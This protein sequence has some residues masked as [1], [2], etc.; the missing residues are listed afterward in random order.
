[1]KSSEKKILLLYTHYSSFVKADFE[2]LSE[3][4]PVD[5]Y[6]FIPHKKLF[7]FVWQFFKQLSFL[8]LKGWKY[9]VFFIWFADYHSL[10]P[11]LFARS[12]GKKSVV[13]VGGYD[14]VSI[15]E[16]G[17]GL[18]YRKNLR[19]WF[20]NHSFRNAAVILP[21]DASLIQST[22]YFVN[23]EGQK[24]GILNYV[25][26]IKALIKTVPTGYRS[27]FWKRKNVKQ[28]GDVITVGGCSDTK[29]FRRKG[30]DFFLELALSMPQYYFTLAGL[31]DDIMAK[32]S[33]QIPSNVTLKGFIS[34]T[35]MIDLF[36]SHHV[37]TQ[38]SL[39][40]GLPNTLCEAMLCGCIPVGSAVNGI[41]HAIGD[42]GFVLNEKDLQ[43]A[44][45]LIILAMNETDQQSP[46]DRI[47][48]LF[49]YNRRKTELYQ[50]IERK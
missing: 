24:I 33:G 26:G 34:Q 12:T 15:P 20:G 28:Q 9:D 1:M 27:D 18:F 25:K 37:F 21:V 35:E 16:I 19:S 49:D 36:S 47:M 4:Y 23:A 41:P 40:E 46:R 7:P 14:A 29:V 38:F 5:R 39:S 43:K 42:S 30:H 45:E 3:K 48:N 8:L 22:N 6:Q 44:Q 31:S 11:I 2:I 17:F 32:L 10:L 13:V 50:I